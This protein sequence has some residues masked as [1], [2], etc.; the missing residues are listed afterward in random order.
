MNGN[1]L[2]YFTSS[3]FFSLIMVKPNLAQFGV[4]HNVAACGRIAPAFCLHTPKGDDF[5]FLFQI[6]YS[7][8]FLS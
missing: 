2:E 1:I 3:N 5:S 6:G 7:V 4:L 8:A